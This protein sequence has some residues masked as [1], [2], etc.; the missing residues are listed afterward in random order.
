VPDKRRY[1]RVAFF[2]PL[3]LTELQSGATV[4]ASSFDI[5]M[6]GVGLTTRIALDRGKAVCVRFC[7][8]HE[9]NEGV[10]EEVLGQVAYCRSDEDGSRIGVEFLQVVRESAQPVLAR[11]LNRL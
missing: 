9:S 6:G 11:K 5:S 4:P 10:F 1:E 8:P 2:C 7:F 3:Q